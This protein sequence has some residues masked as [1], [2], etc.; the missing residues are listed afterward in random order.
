MAARGEATLAIDLGGTRI[1]AGIV[2]GNAVVRQ[3]I[4]P[5]EDELGFDRV[6]RNLIAVGEELM[7][8]ARGI[9]AIGISVPAVVD[10]EQGI[11]VDIRKNLLGL[12]GFPLADLLGKRFGLPVAMENDARL[13]GLGEMVGGAAQ[14]VRDLVCLTFGTG[15]G[16][17]VAIDGRVLRGRHGTG[18]ILG[19]HITIETYGPTCTCGNIGC[20]E[21]LCRA[22]GLVDAAVERLAAHPEHPLLESGRPSPE[23]IFA[24]AAAG[25]EPAG[26]ALAVYLRHMAAGVVSTIH[27]Y[28]PDVVL[29]GGGIMHAADQILPTVREYVQAHAWTIARHPVVIAAAALGDQAALV[30]A[31]ALARGEA[32]F[33]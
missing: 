19:G 20:F 12:I 24:A 23:A 25:D 32:S 8:D 13:Y 6:V 17:C 11:V 30:G 18:S 10:P 26:A 2:A 15:I 33:W 4:R 14:G 5:T 27:A 21:A 1:K 7:H 28:D 9:G 31:A 29:L 16:C 3:I 22:G